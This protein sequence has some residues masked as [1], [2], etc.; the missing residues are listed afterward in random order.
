MTE[1]VFTFLNFVVGILQRVSGSWTERQLAEGWAG[2]A[3][4]TRG[5]GR[6]PTGNAD[7]SCSYL[8]IQR[9]PDTTSCC[10]SHGW[11]YHSSCRALLLCCLFPGALFQWPSAPSQHFAVCN[12]S[13]HSIQAPVLTQCCIPTEFCLISSSIINARVLDCCRLTDLVW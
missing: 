3:I 8:L 13:S 4:V 6:R 7:P 1:K 12:C 11:P 9:S 5:Y 2:A 10:F